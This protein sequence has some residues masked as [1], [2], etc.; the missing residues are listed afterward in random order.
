[1]TATAIRRAT[2]TGG[3]EATTRHIPPKLARAVGMS[4]ATVANGW[5]WSPLT[6]LARMESGHTPSRRRPEYWDGDIPWI[7]IRDAKLNQGQRI[8]DAEQKPNALGI[9]NSSAR[10]LPETTVCLSRTASVGCHGE[11]DGD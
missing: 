5:R 3:R 8:E 4:E 6:K 9:N 10:L 1:M 11:T 7:G 2:T